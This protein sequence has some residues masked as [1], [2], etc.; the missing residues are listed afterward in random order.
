[1]SFD[2]QGETKKREKRGT[3]ITSEVMSM[4]SWRANWISTIWR[5]KKEEKKFKA[6]SL[7]EQEK[8]F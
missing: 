2:L 8:K 1:M 4:I 3:E 6:K 5:G 7:V